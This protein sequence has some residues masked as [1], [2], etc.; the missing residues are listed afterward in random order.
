[1]DWEKQKWKRI[2]FMCACTPSLPLF[3][4]YFRSQSKSIIFNDVCWCLNVIHY[5]FQELYSIIPKA[6]NWNPILNVKHLNFHTLA[7]TQYTHSTTLTKKKKI[8]IQ[9]KMWQC[10]LNC[11]CNKKR[12]IGAYYWYWWQRAH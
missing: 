4:I 3:L 7:Y 11:I 8:I 10:R 1:M 6:N 9:C 2:Y 12:E 5:V